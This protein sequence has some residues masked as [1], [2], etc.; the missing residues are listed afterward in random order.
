MNRF[1][2]IRYEHGLTRG[3]LASASGVN[4]RTLRYIEAGSKPSAP[5]AKALADFYKISV[6]ELLGVNDREVA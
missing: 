2:L 4:E 1:E 6:A 3:E 5:T